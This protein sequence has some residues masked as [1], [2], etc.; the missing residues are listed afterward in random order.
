[1]TMME[2]PL[3]EQKKASGPFLLNPGGVRNPHLTDAKQQTV[4]WADQ[5]R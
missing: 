4:R 5:D 2:S 1:M 3:K